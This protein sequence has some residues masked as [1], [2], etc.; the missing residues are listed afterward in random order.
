MCNSK[1]SLK[2]LS[3]IYNIWNS[4][5]DTQYLK[6]QNTLVIYKSLCTNPIRCVKPVQK[7][8]QIMSNL[9]QLKNPI[10]EYNREENLFYSKNANNLHNKL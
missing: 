2:T 9:L 6:Q 1:F 4:K 5:R 7:W 8:L 10:S 3:Y